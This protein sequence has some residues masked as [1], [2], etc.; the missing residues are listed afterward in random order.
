MRLEHWFKKLSFWLRLLLHRGEVDQE[1]DDEIG[2]HLEAKTE[3]NIAKGM[4]PV[5]ARRAA[6][7][8]LGGVEQV[9]EQVWAARP[10]AWLRR[11]HPG[12]G[13]WR[14]YCDL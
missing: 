4:T 8:E 5:E 10:G 14:Q 11:P 13:H 2:Y 12:F 9:K 3:D 7:I 6:C 1:L